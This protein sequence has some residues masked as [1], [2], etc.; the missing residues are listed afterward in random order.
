MSQLCIYRF[1]RAPPPTRNVSKHGA[2]LALLYH[3]E[4]PATGNQEGLL[5]GS[6]E[7]SSVRECFSC[8]SIM[9]VTIG[10]LAA[11]VI[12][13]LVLRSNPDVTFFQSRSNAP[14]NGCTV[15]TVRLGNSLRFYVLLY[16]SHYVK[17]RLTSSRKSFPL[18]RLR[19]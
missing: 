17:Y 12:A 16:C 5:S 14:I 1:A 8:K 10:L 3:C 2:S 18:A 11:M 6:P 7:N 19:Y 4:T 13:C 15:R 9:A